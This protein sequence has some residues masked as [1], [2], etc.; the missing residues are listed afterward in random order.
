MKATDSILYFPSIEI[1]DSNWLKANALLWD[2]IYRI[3]PKDYQPNDSDDVKRLVD[4]GIVKSLSP[5][6]GDIS[7]T[8]DEYLK[9]VGEL[10]SL[11]DGLDDYDNIHIDKIDVRLYPILEKFSKQLTDGFLQVPSHLARGYMLYLANSMADRRNLNMATNSADAWVTSAYINEK[12]R[13]SEFV[14]GAQDK[15]DIRAYATVSLSDLFP[16]NLEGATMDQVIDFALK[17]KNEKDVLRQS[18]TKFLNDL[19]QCQEPDHAKHI[20]ESHIKTLNSAKLDYKKATSFLSRDTLR[21]SMVVGVPTLYTVLGAMT[22]LLGKGYYLNYSAA[23][24]IGFGAA[25]VERN[26]TST[27]SSNPVGNILVSMDK[28]F[29]ANNSQPNFPSIFDQF[30]ND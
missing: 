25:M 11:P 24:L 3:C 20:I 17:Y 6:K 2:T 9:F 12:G 16:T 4:A 7:D 23:L 21:S 18:V 1:G 30:I 27:Q 15:G 10:P 28:E 5:S 19:R 14:Y 8:Y 22:D 26:F 29:A 13:F